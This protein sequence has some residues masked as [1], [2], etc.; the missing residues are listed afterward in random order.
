MSHDQRG[1]RGRGRGGPSRGAQQYQNGTNEYINPQSQHPFRRAESGDPAS[2]VAG[3]QNLPRHWT[4]MQHGQWQ[5]AR[6]QHAPA[7]YQAPPSYS[8]AMQHSPPPP[9]FN[10]YGTMARGA[11]PMQAS[12]QPAVSTPYTQPATSGHDAQPYASTHTPPQFASTPQLWQ[13][14]NTAATPPSQQQYTPGSWQATPQYP[15][16]P[17]MPM[18]VP[19][20][21]QAHFAA[22]AY[23]PPGRLV[24]IP[25]YGV[26]TRP[27]GDSAP[28]ETPREQGHLPLPPPATPYA[29]QAPTAGGLAVPT[30]QGAPASSAATPPPGL[31]WPT[32]NSRC[33]AC[34]PISPASS[35]VPRC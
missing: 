1:S 9:A 18:G 8:Y 22:T 12:W 14:F 15:T 4:P 26:S 7:D 16:P 32:P 30:E 20:S 11:T 6:E 25:D 27:Q 28:G 34:V 31:P 5:Q 24:P 13:Q 29:M 2:M 23:M 33:R 35:S 19:A 21:Q 17:A 3:G 10:Q